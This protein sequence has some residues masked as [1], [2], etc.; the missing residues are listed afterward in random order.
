MIKRHEINS[1]TQSR[2][3]WQKIKFGKIEIPLSSKFWNYT[4][5]DIES[6]HYGNIRTWTI[7]KVFEKDNIRYVMIDTDILLEITPDDNFYNYIDEGRKILR[8]NNNWFIFVDLDIPDEI[9]KTFADY[10][11]KDQINLEKITTQGNCGEEISLFYNEDIKK[12]EVRLREIKS[13]AKEENK[14][15][16]EQT[17][18]IEKI[19]EYLK[20][21]QN[22][23]II[24][25]EQIRIEN[26]VLTD[27]NEKIK[28]VFTRK[29]IDLFPEKEL[30]KEV[31]YSRS[32][33]SF[34]K[35][36]F[37]GL[38][39]SLVDKFNFY[40]HDEEEAVAYY[41]INSKRF[42]FKVYKLEFDNEEMTKA[43]SELDFANAKEKFLINFCFKI[44]KGKK[45]WKYF[46][47][48]VRIPKNKI[49]RALNKIGCRYYGDNLESITRTYNT[50]L[51]N[52]KK[53]SQVQL[54]LLQE[55]I[56]DKLE[57]D[58]AQIPIKVEV[59]NPENNVWQLELGNH[60]WQT[61]YACLKN[62]TRR[63]GRSDVLD[64]INDLAKTINTNKIEKLEDDIIS[65]L[66]DKRKKIEVYEKKAKKLW[67]D[68]IKK[69]PQKI[70]NV[71][72]KIIIKGKLKTY[73]LEIVDDDVKVYTYPDNNYICIHAKTREGG[74]LFIHD[75]LVQFALALI[76]DSNMRE[77]IYTLS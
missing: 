31:G 69:Y 33:E 11:D 15:G 9:I 65:F 50:Y 27:K 19:D 42:T 66:Q 32:A 77:N 12:V 45:Y 44:K 52:I 1:N 24:E 55:G 22:L 67:E 23:N 5:K 35:L 60:I 64:F 62:A 7:N 20:N 4:E 14:K 2:R 68:T 29:I 72:N 63:Y 13:E 71:D 8:E 56:N 40:Y 43:D 3:I 6:E 47:N 74:D 48:D 57:F 38:F 18:E 30:F 41:K 39:G 75:K 73:K 21:Y 76:N 49:G 26:N 37:K 46:I 34:I 53:Y 54:D 25:D 16:L 17:K 36:D 28:V 61:D 58:N 51:T 59:S 70:L 10:N